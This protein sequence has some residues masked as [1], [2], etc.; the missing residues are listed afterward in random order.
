M[1]SSSDRYIV[2]SI[3]QGDSKAFKFLFDSHYASLCRYA[4]GI[5]HCEETAEDMVMDVFAKL[6]EAGAG[7]EITSSLHGYLYRSVHNHCLNYMTRTHKRF[8]E[9]SPETV[10]VLDKAI[11]PAELYSLPES[12]SMSELSQAIDK[13]MDRLPGECKRIFLMSRT[14][15]LPNKEIALK[16]GISENTV[17]VQICRALKKLRI[18]LCEYLPAQAG[19]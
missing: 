8:T 5:V 19:K 14:D 6:W 12:L 4:M 17:K 1:L 15:D 9:L 3:R 7:L 16:L 11:P 13:S 2:E 10:K 18:M